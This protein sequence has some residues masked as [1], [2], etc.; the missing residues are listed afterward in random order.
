MSKSFKSKNTTPNAWE[1][2]IWAAICG[3]STITTIDILTIS[4][5]SPKWLKIMTVLMTTIVAAASGYK[6]YKSVKEQNEYIN[7]QKQR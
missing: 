7:N 4:A 1:P 3:A 2:A 5:L 6:T